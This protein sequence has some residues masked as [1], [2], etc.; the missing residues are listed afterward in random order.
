MRLPE[1]GGHGGHDGVDVAVG[2]SA[3]FLLQNQGHGKTLES[4]FHA[5]AGVDVEQPELT[6][7]RAGGGSG[8]PGGGG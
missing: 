5:L 7:G 4:R 1:G 8:S 2:Q 6:Q 3:R